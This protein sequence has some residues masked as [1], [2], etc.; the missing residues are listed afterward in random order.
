MNAFL[1]VFLLLFFPIN[2]CG[3]NKPDNVTD[4]NFKV[5]SCSDVDK[6]ASV[7]KDKILHSSSKISAQ[8]TCYYVS[9][10][11]NDSNDGKS[12]GKAWATLSRVS[13]ANLSSGDAV[14]FE[15]NGLWR[16]SL[17][18]K[19]G[20]SYSAYGEGEKPKIFGSLQ[21]YS[22]KEKWL[23]TETPNVYVYDQV[24]END[25][26]LLVFN[27]GEAHSYKK[28]IGI[29]GF[30]GAIGEL[31]N[32]LDMY[33]NIT[34]KR[35][36]LYSDKGNPADR[37]S[38]VE[39]CLKDHIIKIRG[40]KVL[41][42]NLCIKYGGAHGISSG[43]RNGLKV[44]NCEMGWIGGSIQHNTTRYGNAIEIYGGCNDYYVDHCYIYQVYDAGITHQYKDPTSSA[45]KVMENVTYSNNLIEYCIYS[46][47]Y[48][49]NQP[50][51][52]KDLMKNILIKDNICR[53]AG[54][55][56][57]WQRPNKRS[58]HIQS[59]KSI[60]PAEN[61]II[62]GNIFDRSKD[63]L[64]Y[65]AAAKEAHLPEIKNNIYIQNKGGK[66]GMVNGN[67]DQHYLFDLNIENLL[68]QKG[69]DKNPTIIFCDNR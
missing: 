48:F 19:E 22:I 45:T 31:K 58:M 33:H 11:G 26:G 44:T 2:E 13:D 24:L 46:I 1:I 9:K 53:F 27:N 34:D 10:S 17:T 65:I 57:G 6:L 64:I 15:R 67:Y 47:E 5:R 32:D 20:V 28:V 54:Y 7:L 63:D 55:G 14:F 51:S 35:I 69:I 68:K 21:N 41:I 62:T 4:A 29:D 39:F 36:Y 12:P 61:F 40:N 16:G 38:S 42:D 8:G 43:S 30:S 50:K 49:L 59:W 56:W 66:F 18:A 60:N 23:K 52:E 37:Y 3:K 25:A